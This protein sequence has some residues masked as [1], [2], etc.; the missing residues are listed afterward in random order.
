M[1]SASRDALAREVWRAMAKLFVD[2]ER[3]REVVERTGLSF[4][5]TRL[6]RRL[7]DG[8]LAMGEL[9]HRLN[10]DRPNLTTLVDSLESDQLVRRLPHPGDRRITMVEATASGLAAARTAAEVLDRPPAELTSLSRTD[11]E[12]LRRIL[13][14]P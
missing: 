11:L 9:A 1:T 4:A 5:K 7:L 10:V 13:T 8:P 2:G 12:M 14:G 6:L 3:R